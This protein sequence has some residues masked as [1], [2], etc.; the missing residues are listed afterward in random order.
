M[1]KRVPDKP[2]VLIVAAIVVAAGFL[3]WP[4]T[5]AQFVQRFTVQ[6]IL[7]ADCK[8]KACTEEWQQCV[9]TAGPDIG[10][11]HECDDTAGFYIRISGSPLVKEVCPV[12]CEFTTIQAAVDVAGPLAT[13]DVH[14]IVKVG[15]GTYNENVV[16]GVLGQTIPGNITL[17][18]YSRDSVRII[19]LDVAPFPLGLPTL[20]VHGG[21][22]HIRDLTLINNTEFHS[23]LFYTD[24]QVN[25]S[26][27]DN[28]SLVC[29][30]H[31]ALNNGCIL[32]QTIPTPGTDA[33]FTMTNS[34]IEFNVTGINIA[35]GGLI[36][37]SHNRYRNLPN[38]TE[39]VFVYGINYV[40]LV[41][42]DDYRWQSKDETILITRTSDPASFAQVFGLRLRAGVAADAIVDGLT[43]RV[44]DLGTGTGFDVYGINRSGEAPA[45]DTYRFYDCDVV[46][47]R[48]NSTAETTAIQNENTLAG[49]ITVF[50]GRYRATNSDGSAV[51]VSNTTGPAI[52]NVNGVDFITSEGA[53]NAIDTQSGQFSLRLGLPNQ[54]GVCVV[55]ECD[56]ADEAGRVCVNTIGVTGRQTFTCE[57]L[58]GWVEIAGSGGGGGGLTHTVNGSP[59]ASSTAIDFD[60]ALPAAPA[61]SVNVLWFKDA[62]SPTNVAATPDPTGAYTW[63]GPHIFTQKIDTPEIERTGSFT[64]DVNGAGNDVLV[65]LGGTTS[66]ETFQVR[67]SGG[68]AQF[69]VQGDGV[70]EHRRTGVAGV[71][72]ALNLN[73]NPTTAA[74]GDGVQLRF[75]GEDSASNN[76]VFGTMR[77][78]ATNIT[79]PNEHGD[80]IWQTQVG[81]GTVTTVLVLD[82]SAGG[83]LSFG[84]ATAENRTL[85]FE[86]GASDGTITD[87]GT[88]FAFNR[89][90]TD[91]SLPSEL[92]YEDEANVFTLAQRID[93]A[94][95]IRA[96]EL[97]GTTASGG[98]PELVFATDDSTEDVFLDSSSDG[99]FRIKDDASVDVF[100]VIV[101]AAAGLRDVAIDDGDLILNLANATVDDRNL[102]NVVDLA[103][104]LGGTVSTPDVRGLRTT[105]GPTLL[106]MGAVVDLQCLRRN[107]TTIDSATCGGGGDGVG[108]DEVMDEAVGRTK[109]AQLNFI[110]GG[111]SCVDNAGAT[112]TDCTIAGGGTSHEILSGTHTDTTTATVIRGDLMTGQLA[113]PKWQRLAV[114]SAND[115]LGTDGTDVAWAT[116]TGTAS[117][118][119]ANNPLFPVQ[120]RFTAM[121]P[122]SFA[123]GQFF[124]DSVNQSMTFHNDEADVALQ[125]GQEGWIRVRNASGVTISNGQVV[126]VD[127]IDGGLPRVA[128]ARADTL[129][130]A[131]AIGLATHDIETATTGYVTFYGLVRDF[132]TSS[133][134]IADRLYLSASVAGALTNTA[135]SDPNFVVPIGIVT[136]VNVTTGDVLVTLAPPRPTG[137]AGIQV[138]GDSISTLSSEEDFLVSGVLSCGLNTRGKMQVA[139]ST[140]PLQY[141]DNTAT[142]VLRHAAFAASD[143]DALAG[144]SADGFFDAGT[145]EVGRGGT[146]LASGTDGGI[147]GF[148][149]T[150]TLSSSG[151]L[152]ANA[153][154]LGGGA[155]AT[156]STPVGLGTTTTVLH[157]NAA[158]APTFAAVTASDTDTTTFTGVTWGANADFVW[159][160]DTVGG[161]NPDS[162]ISF[163]GANVN[164]S[165]GELQVG[166]NNVVDVLDSPN[167]A[168]GISG[169]YSAG[170]NIDAGS[171]GSTELATANKTFKCNIVLFRDTGLKDSDDINSVSNC[172]RPG[173]A[174]TITEVHCETDAGSPIINLQRDDGA[175]ANILSSDLTCTTGGA[176]GTIAAAEDNFAATDKLDFVGVSGMTGANRV[177][178]LIEYTV[179]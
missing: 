1:W 112:R 79:H 26:R 46:V 72:N 68:V 124:Y 74:I 65:D 85:T 160:F 42:H 43:V 34:F 67:D 110:G 51:D 45:V 36:R 152:T 171:I 98:S 178:V 102:D 3:F 14:V 130:T 69:F 113:T 135:P 174:I 54:A 86:H 19:G 63:T 133:F 35:G 40:P 179:D 142:P 151:L 101:N 139:A 44:T 155:G 163:T 157:G 108:Y 96:L 177:S 78:V 118:V 61:G 41:G 20:T 172:S 9:D 162:V 150:T 131:E 6:Q 80:L 37:T 159:N 128:L 154:I 89:T 153:L 56:A 138:A 90:L 2:W 76:D 31:F 136:E 84:R 91:A 134:T 100:R 148:T 111:V 95:T 137:G 38:A 167:V 141:C 82:G 13:A 18:G 115:I 144:D 109:R 126:Y 106:T 99:S 149:G 70:A 55:A 50:G 59:L 11:V 164:I 121:T 58:A 27:V 107:G 146:N 168:G 15:P 29:D 114:G 83:D 173:R 156:P 97:R 24:D 22:S 125:V 53:V 175:P 165:T 7:D 87:N 143:G 12:G 32:W 169:T 28:V 8:T 117:P 60:D 5:H 104:Q 21:I 93:V 158:G 49:E 62:L 4:D 16:I 64:I 132:D 116:S 161:A 170:L 103:G 88:N 92:A 39:I 57:G 75:F 25:R 73:T 123:A 66:G 119:R 77:T 120:V 33:W 140:T 105:T 47:K 176:N 166:G 23:A 129:A 147:L 94:Q 127:G 71:V 30:S 52:V 17:Q 122:P 145:V 48:P 81:T 10:L